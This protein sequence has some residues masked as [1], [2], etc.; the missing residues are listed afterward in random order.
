MSKIGDPMLIPDVTAHPPA[1]PAGLNKLYALGSSIYL[2]NSDG[3]PIDLTPASDMPSRHIVWDGVNWTSNS[4]VTAHKIKCRDSTDASVLIVSGDTVV[5]TSSIGLNGLAQSANLAGTIT[6]SAGGSTV[7]GSGTAFTTDFVSGDIITTAGNQRRIV[8][9]ITNN[10]SLTVTTTWTSAETAVTYKRGGLAAGGL[11]N[12]YCISN[13]TTTGYL[14]STRTERVVSGATARTLVDLPSGY[15]LYRQL[16]FDVWVDSSSNIHRFA[17]SFV[18]RKV[19]YSSETSTL[20]Y[21]GTVAISPGTSVSVPI[22]NAAHLVDFEIVG[23]LAGGSSTVVL[24]TSDGIMAR[25]A[26]LCDLA[27][28]N[29]YASINFPI[30]YDNILILVWIVGSPSPTMTVYLTA[31]TYCDA[32]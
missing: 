30:Y 17:Y 26:I 4:S 3:I 16:P 28:D 1:P 19:A 13:G 12:L 6:V 24:R 2:Q 11:Y 18:N 22:G 29:V 7:T 31:K 15:T 9:T 21:N 20:L 8:S 5:S 25:Y 32:I 14:L 27:I 23:I 10:T